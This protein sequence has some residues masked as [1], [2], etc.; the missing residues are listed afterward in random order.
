[1]QAAPPAL[2]SFLFKSA[3]LSL[4][5]RTSTAED[6]GYWVLNGHPISALTE[7]SQS[8]PHIL[9][10]EVNSLHFTKQTLKSQKEEKITLEVNKS[11]EHE[12]L[13]LKTRRTHN[14]RKEVRE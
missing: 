2:P 14:R 7:L 9:P 6:L 12:S 4:S 13:L 5:L 11:L 3:H 1:M 10:Q 8:H